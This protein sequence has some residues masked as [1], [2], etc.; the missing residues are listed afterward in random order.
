MVIYKA[1][2]LPHCSVSIILTAVFLGLLTNCPVA[3]P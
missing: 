1:L 2:Q 3:T